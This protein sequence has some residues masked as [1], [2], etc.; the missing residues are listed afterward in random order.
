M[1]HAPL[2]ARRPISTQGWGALLLTTS[3]ALLAT[4]LFA[5]S[6]LGF[7]DGEA[8]YAVYGLHPAPAY[9]DHPGFIGVLARLLAGGLSEA[10]RAPRAHV[11]TA[12]FATLVPLVMGAAARWAGAPPRRALRLAVITALVPELAIGLFGLTPDLPFALFFLLTAGLVSFSL[13]ARDE[14]RAFVGHLALLAAAVCAGLA[15]ISKA[16]GLV[17]IPWLFASAWWLGKAPRWLVVAA[18]VL[19]S[20][21]V[22]PVAISELIHG[23][24]MLLHRLVHTQGAAGFSP[25]NAAALVGGQLLYASPAVVIAAVW[26]AWQLWQRHRNGLRRHP[27][28]AL[29]T[30]REAL[31]RDPVSLAL[32][33][34]TIATG[35][36]LALLCLWSPV[37]EPHW[38]APTWLPLG[39]LWAR[40]PPPRPRRAKLWRTIERSLLPTAAVL[41]AIVHVYVLTDIFPRL[42]G[43]KYDGRFDLA[44]DMM[45]YPRAGLTLRESVLR[46][47][48]QMPRSARQTTPEPVIVAPHW[49]IAAQVATE[50]PGTSRVTTATLPGAP[51]DDFQRWVPPAER[52]AAAVVVFVTDDRF[53]PTLPPPLTGRPILAETHVALE[54]GGRPVRTVTVRTLGPAPSTDLARTF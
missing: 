38:F 13:R 11:F 9:V 34:L 35:A 41:V 36:P 29:H 49:T 16:P 18:S 15:A 28:S 2:A 54:R 47:K 17:L 26:V 5:A 42:M 40:R 8:L 7:G 30:P 4:R 27:R 21:F 19:A 10:V 32:L 3:S 14:A 6:R 45:T 37:A 46:A 20:V 22:V 12:V 48:L 24:P 51:D 25:R 31:S 44:N 1:S 53:P 52:D 39:L 33:G 50:L 43:S 23:A